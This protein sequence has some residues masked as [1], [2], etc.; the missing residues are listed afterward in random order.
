MINRVKIIVSIIL[1]FILSVTTAYSVPAVDQ[2]VSFNSPVKMISG[3]VVK[4]AD[5]NN[6]SIID[7]GLVCKYIFK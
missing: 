6:I 2:A 4:L 1:L 5:L 7:A 3:N